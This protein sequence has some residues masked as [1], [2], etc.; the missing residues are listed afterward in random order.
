MVCLIVERCNSNISAICMNG[1]CH[2]YQWQG[3]QFI[4]MLSTYGFLYSSM[5]SFTWH[6]SCNILGLGL[7]SLIRMTGTYVLVEFEPTT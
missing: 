2:N 1:G 5:G 7:C 6:T 3:C 4:H